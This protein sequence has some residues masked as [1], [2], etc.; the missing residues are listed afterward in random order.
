MGRELLIT[1]PDTG[2]VHFL[3]ATAAEV[4]D[5]CDG[6][7][8]LAACEERLR[9]RFAVPGTVNL[10]SDIA[11]ILRDLETRGLLLTSSPEPA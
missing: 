11:V 1:D 2:Q 10:S 6:Q 7:V 3:N 9:L 5:C 8:T 4:W